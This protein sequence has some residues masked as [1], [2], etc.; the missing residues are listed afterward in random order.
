MI[1]IRRGFDIQEASQWKASPNSP[2]GDFGGLFESL[3]KY[4]ARDTKRMVAAGLS[5]SVQHPF[6]ALQSGLVW[7]RKVTKRAPR[8]RTYWIPECLDGIS[9]SC[10]SCHADQ[11]GMSTGQANRACLLNSACLRASG[12]SPRHSAIHARVVQSRTV[13]F[14]N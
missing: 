13:S 4:F 11:F 8:G 14:I 10:K 3:M 5:P 12:A 9:A 2:D 7:G 6:R 1:V